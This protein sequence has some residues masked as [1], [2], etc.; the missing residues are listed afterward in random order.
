MIFQ[1]HGI[2]VEIVF[3]VWFDHHSFSELLSWEKG[4]LWNGFCH[5]GQALFF[6]GT[7]FWKEGELV[8]PWSCS[9]SSNCPEIGFAHFLAEQWC[10]F[11]F[12]ASG[13]WIFQIL[14]RLEHDQVWLN[15][16]LES[17]FGNIHTLRLE[18]WRSNSF[19]VGVHHLYSFACLWIYRF[20][21]NLFI[22]LYHLSINTF[23]YAALNTSYPRSSTRID[24]HRLVSNAPSIPTISR[25]CPGTQLVSAIQE[26]DIT[27][28]QMFAH[29]PQQQLFLVR[30][31]LVVQLSL[32][33]LSIFMLVD[34]WSQHVVVVLVPC[35]EWISHHV[36]LRWASFRVLRHSR[37]VCSWVETWSL[38][39]AEWVWWG[40]N[41]EVV[42][43]HLLVWKG[44]FT[45]DRIWWRAIV[46]SHRCSSEIMLILQMTSRS[47]CVSS[48]PWWI[49]SKRMGLHENR[50]V[51]YFI[52][53]AIIE[54]WNIPPLVP[55]LW[56]LQATII[57]LSPPTTHSIFENAIGH[58]SGRK[59]A[60]LFHMIPSRRREYHLGLCSLL[61]LK[62]TAAVCRSSTTEC[63]LASE[64]N[65]V[66][67]CRR[68]KC[69]TPFFA[70]FS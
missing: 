48:S 31:K 66:N 70:L 6:W 25:Q 26:E 61:L 2:F 58:A 64:L 68:I 21:A 34:C 54:I 32:H 11:S 44:G 23:V 3:V 14:R 59:K 27:L 67:M 29:E 24:V 17:N 50:F 20:I 46:I 42:G 52:R 45:F 39:D 15:Q 69:M 18:F 60:S 33:H 1:I 28:A 47:V 5:F 49:K 43:T 57:I 22:S 36:D 65:S 37:D 53:F 8:V 56:L 19:S 10:A 9:L 62:C 41:T 7:W 38:A 40:W 13:W 51:N 63:L 4:S 12:E 16:L 35:F 30:I 55:V